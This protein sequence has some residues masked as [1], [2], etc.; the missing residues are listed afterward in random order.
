[1]MFLFRSEYVCHCCK[2]RVKLN[3]YA[4]MLVDF[5][6]CP[7]KNNSVNLLKFFFLS[8]IFKVILEEVIFNTYLLSV[9]NIQCNFQFGFFFC[10]LNSFTG[11]IFCQ[12]A[13]LLFNQI[14]VGCRVIK[15]T[16][17]YIEK[18]QL[19]FQLA[20]NLLSFIKKK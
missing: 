1:M 20:S 7:L 5:Q 10:R 11:K 6:K 16:E 15:W 2:K 12:C 13:K 4:Q 9:L 14:I 18:C 17:V 8:Q 3:K 19:L